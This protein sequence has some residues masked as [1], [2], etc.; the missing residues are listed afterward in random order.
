[1]TCEGEKLLTKRSVSAELDKT[2]S[3]GRYVGR[4]G[5][6]TSTLRK[7]KDISEPN[8]LSGAVGEYIEDCP[9]CPRKARQSANQIATSGEL[10]RG[11][12][13][14]WVVDVLCQ[15]MNGVSLCGHPFNQSR[16]SGVL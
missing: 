10:P 15:P 11:S 8:W 4:N 7:R 14:W 6:D 1:M 13:G 3:T 5:V 16:R 12:D 2:N 9:S